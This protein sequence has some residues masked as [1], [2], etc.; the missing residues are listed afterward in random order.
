MANDSVTLTD[1]STGRTIELPIRRG[2]H[3]PPV[4]DIGSL[5]KELGM[6]TYDPGFMATA[7]CSSAITFIDGEEGVLLYRG[8]P[9]EQLAQHSNFLEVCYLLWYGRLP[10]KAEYDLYVSTI[11]HHTMIHEGLKDFYSGF[12]RGAHPMAV[13][14]GVVGALSA[15]YH[16]FL[17]ITDPVHREVSGQRLLAKM[18]TIAA[19]A[20]R[21]SRG[22]PFMYPRNELAYCANFL[23]M[24]FAFP[25]ET[26]EI[27]PVAA[28]ALDLILLLHADHEQ[29]AST[30]TVRLAGSTMS[31]PFAAVSAGVG[32]LWGPSHGG[33]SEAVVNMLQQIGSVSEIPKYVA[34]AHDPKDSF[35][36]MGFGHRVYKHYDP[37]AA[38]IRKTAYDVL[39]ALHVNDPLFEIALKLEEIAT[40]DAYFIEKKL[41]PNVDFYSGI[42]LRALGIPTNMFTVIF[43][44]GRTIGWIS[45]WDE[46][47]AAKDLKI[48]RPRQLYVGEKKRD[49]VP[50]AQ[51]EVE[52]GS[53]SVKP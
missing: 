45:Q 44:M 28:K 30:S 38:I 10:S 49:Y 19:W 34:R 2:S 26:A 48:G 23:N 6:F 12:H 14:V 40:K 33:A 53:R 24:M 13:M 31:N 3:G 29:N 17:N 27:N 22:L 25:T 43:T 21:Y 37:R 4:I 5:Y 50:I 1:N 8:Y 18:P 20:Y 9:I 41:Y 39:N 11:T 15:F 16:D 42:I 36:L 46:M 51:R 32:A 52:K 47:L 35:R 7:A